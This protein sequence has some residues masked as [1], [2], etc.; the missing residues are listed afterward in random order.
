[1]WLKCILAFTVQPTNRNKISKHKPV[2]RSIWP[3]DGLSSFNTFFINGVRSYYN[4]WLCSGQH[5]GT[6]RGSAVALKEVDIPEENIYIDKKSGKDFN[7][8]Q[9]KRLLKKIHPGDLLYIKSI[10][11][12]GH[13]CEEI[14]NQWRAIT[15]DKGVNILVLDMPLLDT[16]RRKDLLE[17]FISDLVLQLLSF[18]EE[19]GQTSSSVRR[20][21]LRR[22]RLGMRGLAGHPD[23]YQRIFKRPTSDGSKVKSPADW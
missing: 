22:Q 2:I 4:L 8:P 1:L 9:Y 20:R 17:A 16:R 14:Q 21:E 18:A 19:N 7:R 12:L 10:D 5:P 11:H 6:K 15:K 3:C 13:N 23:T